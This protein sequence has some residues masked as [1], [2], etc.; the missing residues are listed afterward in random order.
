VTG[1]VEAM[2]TAK[3]MEMEELQ[4]ENQREAWEQIKNSKNKNK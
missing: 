2:R 3:D 1:L 4:D